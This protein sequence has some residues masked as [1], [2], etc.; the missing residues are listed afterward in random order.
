M[1]IVILDTAQIQPFIFASNRLRDNAGA[2]YLVSQATGQW[3]LDLLPQ[4]N[5]VS[6]SAA[7]TFCGH[8]TIDAPELVQQAQAEVLYAGGGNVVVL[9]QQRAAAESYLRELSKKVLLD[10]P[11]LRLAASCQEFDCNDFTKLYD[12]V[13]RGFQTLNRQKQRLAV[14]EPVMGLGVTQACRVSGQ[15]ASHWSEQLGDQPKYPVSAGIHCKQ[16]AR[17]SAMDRLSTM[18]DPGAGFAYPTEF[19]QL[20]RTVGEFSYLAVVH[21]D[22]NGMGQ[23]IR[24]VGKGGKDREYVEAMRDFSQAL[25]EVG[26]KALAAAIQ[27]LKSRIDTKE[28]K[29]C[30]PPGS[31]EEAIHTVDLQRQG[32]AILLP[33]RPLVYGGDDVTFVCDGRLGVSLAVEYLTH[34]EKLS[35]ALPDGQGPAFAC[36]GI[37]IVRSHYPFARAYDLAEQLCGSAKSF[38]RQRGQSASALD[39]HFANTGLAGSLDEIRR[40]EMTTSVGSLLMR[41]VM[42][43]HET[44]DLRTWPTMVRGIREF[45][46][47]DWREK[48]NKIKAFREVLRGQ[49]ED[50]TAFCLKYFQNAAP[51]PDLGLQDPQYRRDGW[52]TGIDGDNRCAYFD[53]IELADWH[54][55]LRKQDHEIPEDHTTQ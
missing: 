10:A 21:A 46:E 54:V 5:N 24:N 28:A 39:W 18:L 33:I 45:R 12:A 22:G 26:V 30:W 53:M 6:D 15:P 16:R 32:D 4:P 7:G 8:L 23:R 50:V 48:R 43:R 36:A 3:A 27:Q 20:G 49:R 9:F 1:Q 17:Y 2:S 14:S 40:Q 19:D 55:P 35:R 25:N 31:A 47:G 42:L 29:I 13:Q 34:F 41:P 44:G 52:V 37:S 11:G 38:V 51:L